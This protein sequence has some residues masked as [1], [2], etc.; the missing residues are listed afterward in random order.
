MAM[1]TV[2]GLPWVMPKLMLGP[3]PYSLACQ[4][5]P[6]AIVK[7]GVNSIADIPNCIYI[8]IGN[9]IV[10]NNSIPNDIV[11]DNVNNIMP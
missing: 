5:L 8:G 10:R 7:I 9:S 2:Y 4:L 3:M 1:P 6:Y 11:K